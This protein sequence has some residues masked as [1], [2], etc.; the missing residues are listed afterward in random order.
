MGDDGS[1]WSHLTRP[2]LKDEWRKLAPSPMPVSRYLRTCYKRK[3]YYIHDLI[4][5]AF[6]GPRPPGQECRH[7]NGD[8][9]DNRP[10]NLAWGTRIENAADKIRHGTCARFTGEKNPMAKLTEAQVIYARQQRSLGRAYS[11]IADELRITAGQ[12]GHLCRRKSWGHI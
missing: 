12:V 5:Q 11:S 9:A 6:V 10:S 8:K 2:G 4:L 7:I 1:V 3:T